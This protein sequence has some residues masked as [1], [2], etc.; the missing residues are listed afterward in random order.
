LRGPE[1]VTWFARLEPDQ[2]NLRFAL[3]WALDETRYEDVGWLIVAA[4]WFWHFR[5]RWDERGQWLQQLLPHRL[6]LPLDL[7]LTILISLYATARIRGEGQPFDHWVGELMELLPVCPDKLQHASVW[8]FTAYYADDLPQAAS[9][10]ELSIVLARAASEPSG[11]GR[12]FGVVTDRDFVLGN[13]IWAYARCL[14]EHGEFARALPLLKESLEIFQRR[15]S[16]YEIVDSLGTLGRLALLQGDL[17]QAHKLLNEAVTIAADFNYQQRLGD[18]QS[19]LGLVIL[20]G[21]DMTEARR[22]LSES[23]NRCLAQKHTVP[24]ARVCSFLAETALCEGEI[25]ETEQWLRQSLAYH[26]NPQQ[27]RIEQVERFG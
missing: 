25:D 18:L 24:L 3:R 21:G 17:A 6:G 16:G 15:G 27:V 11:L 26:A 20:Y 12:K 22:L 14:I 4:E 7:R 10:W 23:L 19:L 1:A 9:A 8:H 2:D 5:G 13:S